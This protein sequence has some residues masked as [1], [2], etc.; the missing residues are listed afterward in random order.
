MFAALVVHAGKRTLSTRQSTILRCATRRV[1]LDES[2]REVRLIHGDSYVRR[3]HQASAEGGAPA[4]WRCHL[5]IEGPGGGV[6]LGTQPLGHV[7]PEEF[8]W[9]RTNGREE[10]SRRSRK[11]NRA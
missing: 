4:S 3:A 11:G 10:S 8:A 2:I 6:R 9:I 7:T 5:R 1:P